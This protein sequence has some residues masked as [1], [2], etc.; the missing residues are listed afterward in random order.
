MVRNSYVMGPVFFLL[1][2]RNCYFWGLVF[3]RLEVKN[4]Y[5]SELDF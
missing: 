3:L 2:V 4:S 5:D 1:G